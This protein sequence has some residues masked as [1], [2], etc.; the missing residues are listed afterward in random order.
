MLNDAI[1]ENPDIICLLELFLSLGKKFDNGIVNIEE[2]E[3]YQTLAKNNNVNIILGSVALKSDINN[4]TTNTCFVIDRK[5]EIVK[6]YDKKYMYKVNKPD[7]VVDETEDT[8]PGTE[9]GI[10]QKVLK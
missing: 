10:A 1:K 9:I 4:K 3:K 8:I 2:I 7:F 6:R 5:G